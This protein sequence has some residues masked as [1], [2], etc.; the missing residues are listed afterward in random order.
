MSGWLAEHQQVIGMVGALVLAGLLIRQ[1]VPGRL[2]WADARTAARGRTCTWCQGRPDLVVYEPDR[3][4]VPWCR[5]HW[6]LPAPFGP[7]LSVDHVVVGLRS[8]ADP[9]AWAG[10]AVALVPAV[11]VLAVTVAMATGG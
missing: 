3:R 1:T 11:L 4:P 8:P 10:R 6:T 5:E 7:D 2:L 9:V